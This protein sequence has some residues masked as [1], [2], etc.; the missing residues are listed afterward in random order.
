MLMAFMLNT[1]EIFELQRGDAIETPEE[2]CSTTGQ[3]APRTEALSRTQARNRNCCRR[4]DEG[5]A[6]PWGGRTTR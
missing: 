3:T 4:I 5:C 6:T 2:A 1:Y